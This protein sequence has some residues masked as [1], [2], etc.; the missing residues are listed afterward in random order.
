MHER[1]DQRVRVRVLVL[2]ALLVLAVSALGPRLGVR[3][4]PPDEWQ[5]LVALGDR[6][7]TEPGS[8]LPARPGQPTT[9]RMAYLLAFHEAQDREDLA[10]IFLAAERL[11]RIG[12][13][14]LAAHVREA[15]RFVAR[16]AGPRP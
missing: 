16:T 7:A 3:S 6:F 4:A 8:S 13:T 10:R 12:E 14:A 11:E 15:A 2:V 5:R 1:S 9:A